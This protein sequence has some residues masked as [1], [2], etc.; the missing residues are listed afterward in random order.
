MVSHPNY[1]GLAIAKRSDGSYRWT[2]PN[3]GE[4]RD[5]RMEWMKAK[6][7]ELGISESAG[8]SAAVMLR[9]HPSKKKVCQICGREMSLYYHYPNANFLK[10]LN[11]KFG[12]S[13]TTCDHIS[14]I[15]DALL[16]QGESVEGISSF[17]IK[18]CGLS[19]DPRATT[20]DEVINVAEESC[21]RFGKKCFGPG[22]MSNFPDRFDGFHSYNR[23]CRVNQDKGR[24]KENMRSYTQDRR[25]YEYWSDGNIHAANQF[26]GTRFF[27]NVSAD[28]IGPIS[29][30]FIH[31]P[32]YLQPMLR[33]DNST[34]R[35]RLQVEDIEKIIEVERRTGVYPISWYSRE[36]WKFIRKN[37]ADNPLKVATAYRDVLKQN[38][39]NFMYILSVILD[40]CGERGRKVLSEAFLKPHQ[41]DFQY[42]YKFNER[43]EI[44]EQSPRHFTES[45]SNEFERY[46]RIAF[47]AVNDYKSKTNRNVKNGLTHAECATLE[48]IC[49]RIN[50]LATVKDIKK[51]LECLL[52]TIEAR[53]IADCNK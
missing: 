44:V 26:M 30:G 27:E 20:K 50:G 46:E 42:S 5:R 15:W 45:S 4:I 35:D 8:M 34:K 23:C 11:E 21:R 16:R 3:K 49:G 2:E 36:I 33:G 9:I 18:K 47:E 38:M 1:T 24:S 7:R 53:L 10:A 39:A 14:D 40:D 41:E 13:F 28:H 29:L 52:T 22:A 17:L 19:L 31:D 32:R 6:A 51:E 12:T 37:Y 25:A 43:G 48:K